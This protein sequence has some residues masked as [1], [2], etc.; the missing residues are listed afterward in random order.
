M[1]KCW[2]CTPVLCVCVFCSV[3]GGFCYCFVVG[4]VCCCFFWGGCL[5]VWGFGGGATINVA[6]FQLQK[7]CLNT[8]PVCMHFFFFLIVLRSYRH[9][10]AYSSERRDG[11]WRVRE[12]FCVRLHSRP[13]FIVFLFFV[14][15]SDSNYCCLLY[16]RKCVTLS[17]SAWQVRPSASDFGIIL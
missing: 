7:W 15:R 4:F 8:T 5:F 17:L 1:W 9:T 13:R 16:E 10:M 6:A 2:V 3:F 12:I 11:F 14:K